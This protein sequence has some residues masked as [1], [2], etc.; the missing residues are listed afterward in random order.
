MSQTTPIRLLIAEDH[1]LSRQGL[2]YGLNKHD[3]LTV[4]GEAE[5]GQEAVA[6]AEDLKPD[7]IL[8]D[9]VMP[10]LNGIGA[11]AQIKA[12]RPDTR[13]IML[14]SH[15]EEDKVFEAFS[16]GADGY[17][18]KDIKLDRLV[19]VIEL[20]NDGG[21]WIDPDIAQ[22]IVGALP[23]LMA[24]KQQQSAGDDLP[25]ALTERELEILKLMAEGLNNKDI[26][27]RLSISLY[28]VKNHVSNVIGKLAVD[29]RTQAAVYAHKHG[30]I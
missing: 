28:T 15:G 9:I 22:Y 7:V 12:E 14:T 6:M 1:E 27:D 13:I 5:H 17:C 4:V 24:L 2:I 25:T 11:T 18:L 23:K 26:A 19:G 3:R 21:L 8:M 29:D 30:L 20:V 16:A 10:V